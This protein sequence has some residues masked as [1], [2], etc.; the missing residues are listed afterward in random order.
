MISVGGMAYLGEQ[1]RFINQGQTFP[2][3][4]SFSPGCTI[5]SVERNG[6]VR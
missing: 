4:D 6:P 3:V 2:R 1:S 5:I